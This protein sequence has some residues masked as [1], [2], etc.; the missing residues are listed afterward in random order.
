MAALSLESFEA[1]EADDNN[2]AV[3]FNDGYQQGFDAGQAA[4]AAD[5]MAL[6]AALVQSISDIDF[7]YAEAR[8]QVMQSLDPLFEALTTAVLPHCISSGYAK[9][10][11]DILT[12]AA[13]ADTEG[14]FRLHVHPDQVP[15]VDAATAD[16]AGKIK[17]VPDAALSAHAAWIQHGAGETHLDLD[18]LLTQITEALGAVANPEYRTA[19]HG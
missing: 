16:L 1:D 10:V 8:A 18:R 6:A 2:A 19:T 9:Q 12:S 14:P 4:A 15:A 13:A 3:A 17:I 5:H 11:A 7:T